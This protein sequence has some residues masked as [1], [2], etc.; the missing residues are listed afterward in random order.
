MDELV[1]RCPDCGFKNETEFA[2]CPV[3][4]RSGK[5]DWWCGACEA[6]RASR[7]C[8]ACSGLLDAPAEVSLGTYPP[9]GRI[10]VKFTVRNP[11]KKLLECPVSADPAV[12]LA[13]R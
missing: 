5:S 6:W 13:S 4:G 8:P 12:T 2:P 10:P 7:A 1:A 11:G 3:C 9:A